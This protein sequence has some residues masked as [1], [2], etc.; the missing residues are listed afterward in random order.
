MSW[1][2]LASRWQS[3]F[4]VEAAVCHCFR[5]VNSTADL[6]DAFSD[7]K[8]CLRRF[9]TSSAGTKVFYRTQS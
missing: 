1:R 8:Q 5:S 6:L 9:R 2:V 3:C 7:L 4:K